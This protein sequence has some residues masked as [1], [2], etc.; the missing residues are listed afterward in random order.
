MDVQEHTTCQARQANPSTTGVEPQRP[1]TVPNPQ[2]LQLTVRHG[3]V[4]RMGTLVYIYH[5]EKT[6]EIPN[7]SCDSFYPR[8]SSLH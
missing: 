7:I 3:H 6:L 8:I 4:P 5:E 1:K 2:K